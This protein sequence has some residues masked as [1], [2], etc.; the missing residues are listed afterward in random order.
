MLSCEVVIVVLMIVLKLWLMVNGWVCL[1]VV[2][3]GWSFYDFYLVL[4]FLFELIGVVLILVYVLVEL[5]MGE[6]CL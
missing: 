1:I 5:R 2:L 6:F 3:M 4:L